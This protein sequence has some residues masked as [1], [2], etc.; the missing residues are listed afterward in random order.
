VSVA[1][2]AKAFLLG[3]DSGVLA[4][5]LSDVQV[6]YTAPRDIKRDIVYGGSVAGSVELS[7]M[8]GGGR[9]KRQEDLTL[10]LVV[11]VYRAGQATTEVS[12]A[13][14]V[15][16]G[17]V[18]ANYLAANWKLGSLPSLMKAV[19]TGVELDGWVDDDGAGS[20]LTIAVGLTSYLT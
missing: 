10:A 1:A 4:G 14:A 19:V 9:V 12:D 17:D 18:I 3:K 7:A 16:I 15:E 13:R 11:R 8:A 20:V 5:L 2:S 6:T